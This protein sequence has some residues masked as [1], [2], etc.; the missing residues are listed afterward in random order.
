[1]YVS[2]VEAGE[3]G[4]NLGELMQKQAEFDYNQLKIE[5]RIKKCHAL[6]F[7]YVLCC[8]GYYYFYDQIYSA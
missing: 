5:N 7:D 8:F 2:L 3:L 1:M 4:G 6:S